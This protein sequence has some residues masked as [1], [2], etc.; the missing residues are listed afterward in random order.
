MA[1]ESTEVVET[2]PEVD[3][4]NPNID[5]TVVADIQYWTKRLP[6]AFIIILTM[7]TIVTV[8]ICL[9]LSAGTGI[10]IPEWEE[11]LRTQKEPE[12]IGFS[13]GGIFHTLYVNIPYLTS[14]IH[15]LAYVSMIGIAGL[16]YVYFF[17]EHQKKQMI[18]AMVE[19]VE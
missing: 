2:K 16:F 4:R 10:T 19:K 13:V 18:Q 5:W 7:A 9:V 8:L 11:F 14:K 3:A 6:F 17:R 15:P 12:Y 1:S